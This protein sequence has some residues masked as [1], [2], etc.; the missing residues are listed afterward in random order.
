LVSG[1]LAVAIP[2]EIRGYWA[3]HQKFGKLSWRELFE[4]AI[5]MCREGIE[6]FK[7]SADALIANKQIIMDEPSLRCVHISWRENNK[8]NFVL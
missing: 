5:E 6:V 3:A 8:P 2:G 4:P 7:P 1:G